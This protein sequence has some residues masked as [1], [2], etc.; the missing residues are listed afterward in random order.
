MRL[1]KIF[2]NNSVLVVTEQGKEA[3]V[4]GNGVGFSQGKSK[5]IDT[6]KI[7]KIFYLNSKKDK[8]SFDYLFRNI[9]VEIVAVV[10]SIIDKAKKDYKFHVYDSIYLTLSEHI[11]G[12]YSLLKNNEYQENRIPNFAKEYPLEYRIS[13]AALNIINHRLGVC[14]P[15][16]EIRSLA[17]HFINSKIPT[18]I[19]QKSK[20]KRRISNNSRM[21]S[22]VMNVLD[23]N[24]I[25]QN[26]RNKNSFRRLLIHIQYLS[27]RIRHPPVRKE[28]IDKKIQT[29][30]IMAYPKSF[31][32]TQEIFQKFKAEF[33]CQLSEAE[34]TYFVIH[35]HQILEQ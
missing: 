15:K 34:E 31:K 10:F 33:N 17:L 27:N 4:F 5:N 8:E 24:N 11:N 35:I 18:G 14:F 32:I 30:L 7:Q 16:S 9:P 12:A 26:A 13:S 28:T 2:N 29:D 25:Y 23:D 1:K 6:S 22:I 21:I 19:H 20:K 3:I